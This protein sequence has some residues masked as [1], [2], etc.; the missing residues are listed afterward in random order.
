M[1]WTKEK[2]RQRNE[3]RFKQGLCIGCGKVKAL[4]GYSFC[5][6]CREKRNAI[7]RKWNAT[8]AGYYRERYHKLKEQGRCAHCGGIVEDGKTH[9][10]A[11]L[12]NVKN[13]QTGKREKKKEQREKATK[14][15]MEIFT[16]AGLKCEIADERS[17]SIRILRKWHNF[18]YYPT[19]GRL[20]GYGIM[21]TG[22]VIR[23]VEEVEG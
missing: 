10:P 20:H 5:I 7:S 2:A 14:E 16:A 8:H 4:P 23:K 22:E 12:E 1:A 21:E 15:A 9:C 17:G 13:A 18:Y 3:E 11:C 6:S 19:T